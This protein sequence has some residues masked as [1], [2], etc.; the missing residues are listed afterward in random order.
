MKPNFCFFINNK[1]KIV[2]II[3]MLAVLIITNSVK[4]EKSDIRN[5]NSKELSS[6]NLK[7]EK[8]QSLEK[9]ESEVKDLSSFLETKDQLNLNLELENTNKSKVESQSKE[10]TQ[11]A[12]KKLQEMLKESD[13]IA[14]QLEKEIKDYETQIEKKK[15]KKKVK[16]FFE[17]ELQN[18]EIALIQKNSSS[19]ML[20][21]N[22]NEK[23]NE[24]RLTY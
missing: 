10:K 24:F 1:S 23:L 3:V 8:V 5:K 21:E 22:I 20:P 2:S 19:K 7:N 15:D 18:N 17:E 9:K 6:V 13:E 4:I 11:L 16:N 12:E 14:K